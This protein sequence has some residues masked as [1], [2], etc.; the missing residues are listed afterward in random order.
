MRPQPPWHSHADGQPTEA[1]LPPPHGNPASRP[2]PPRATRFVLGG[3][4]IGAIVVGIMY[5]VGGP[6]DDS[7]DASSAP[8]T[9]PNAPSAGALDSPADRACTRLAAGSASARTEDQRVELAGLVTNRALRSVTPRIA[10]RAARLSSAARGSDD[11]WRGAV[12]LL[13]GTC[14]T[15]G[16]SQPG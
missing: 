15:A 8:T 13:A 11:T 2:P 10:E 6:G 14:K 9:P 4:A 7:A 12:D 1:P 3:L 5:T 16:W